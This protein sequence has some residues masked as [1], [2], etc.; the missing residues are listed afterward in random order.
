MA[1]IKIVAV[2]NKKK[3]KPDPVVNGTRY[4]QRTGE[5]RLRGYRVGVWV[6]GWARTTLLRG[7]TESCKHIV[8]VSLGY[9]MCYR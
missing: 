2:K 1:T 4:M 8:I 7:A 9:N 3:I 5:H 6:Y